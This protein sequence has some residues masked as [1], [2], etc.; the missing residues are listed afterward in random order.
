MRIVDPGEMRLYSGFTLIT[1][2]FEESFRK[3]PVAAKKSGAGFLPFM[4][5]REHL[6]VSFNP[7]GFSYFH[8]NAPFMGVA[9]KPVAK[10]QDLRAVVMTK[11]QE[12]TG[13]NPPSGQKKPELS[14]LV[15]FTPRNNLHHTTLAGDETNTENQSWKCAF[16]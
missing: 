1:Y 7:T 10:F 11:K 16:N 15:L 3:R 9:D 6:P 2:R 5:T 4:A 13:G 12:S 14:C 8:L